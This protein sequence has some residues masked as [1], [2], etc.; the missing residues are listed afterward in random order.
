MFRRAVVGRR[1]GTGKAGG[2]LTQTAPTP[3]LRDPL[4]EWSV[5]RLARHQNR[6]CL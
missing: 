6:D 3:V 4:T 2:L 5:P 1:R